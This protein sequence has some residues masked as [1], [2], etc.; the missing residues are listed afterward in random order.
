LPPFGIQFAV[1]IAISSLAQANGI[2]ADN[3]RGTS[4]FALPLAKTTRSVSVVKSCFCR[5][6]EEGDDGISKTFV[7]LT[8]FP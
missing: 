2:T 7:T 6:E 5:L 1:R 4:N 8:T 3:S